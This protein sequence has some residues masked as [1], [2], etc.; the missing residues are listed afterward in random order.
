MVLAAMARVA[1]THPPTIIMKCK[2]MVSAG[3][4][5]SKAVGCCFITSVQ[6]AARFLSVAT[7][8][9]TLMTESC[10]MRLL[11]VSCTPFCLLTR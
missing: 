1:L 10:L 6:L 4:L 7:G 5:L 9:K 11:E 3:H 8:L 2:H